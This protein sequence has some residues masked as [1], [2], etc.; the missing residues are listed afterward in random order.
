MPT[1]V[2]DKSE[3]AAAAEL[4]RM[5]GNG[6]RVQILLAMKVIQNPETI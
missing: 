5:I 4:L 2:I 1:T 6:V 3:T